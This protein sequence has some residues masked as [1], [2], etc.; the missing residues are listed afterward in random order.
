MNNI[1]QFFA[2]V[3]VDEPV[4]SFGTGYPQSSNMILGLIILVA[5]CLAATITIELLFALAF[6]VRKKNLGIVVLAQII[7]NPLVVLISNFTLY[8]SGFSAYY[9]SMAILEVIAF[10]AEGLIY[11]SFFEKNINR[12]KMNPFLLSLLLNLFSFL[13]GMFLPF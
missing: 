2:D 3:A 13:I 1:V 11:T 4:G 10:I 9:V 6:G 8:S 7:T 12:N 5:I